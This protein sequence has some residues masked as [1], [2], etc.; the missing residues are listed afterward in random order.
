MP[1]STLEG[2]KELEKLSL[3]K[4]GYCKLYFNCKQSKKND[5]R[6]CQELYN[7]LKKYDSTDSF[8][9]ALTCESNKSLP[10]KKYN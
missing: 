8:L 3:S 5:S 1:N 2:L 4:K 9:L 10:P 7:A 6:A